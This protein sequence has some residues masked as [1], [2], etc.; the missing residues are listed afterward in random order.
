[1]DLLIAHGTLV[2]MDPERRIIE[3]GAVL[4]QG[5]RIAAVGSAAELREHYPDVKT[6]DAA[7]RVVTPGLVNTHTHLFQGLLKGL[8]DD[9]VLV[10]WFRQ[11]TGPSAVHLTP[12][13][14]YHAARLG[15]LE[16]IRS[17]A[18]TLLDFMYPHAQPGLSAPI[19]RAFQESGIRG[20]FARGYVDYGLEEGVPPEII[21]DT[22]QA[23]A[24][25][26]QLFENYHGSAEGRIQVWV[27]PCMIW[28]QT[29]GGLLA[30]R[31]LANETGMRISVHVAETPFE[32][33]NAR[34]RFGLKDLEYLASIGFLG[35]DVLAV[36]GVYLDERDIR[37]L[38]QHDVKLSHNPVS[39]MYLSSGVAPIPD[40]L[41]AGITVGLATDGPASNN[42]QNMIQTLKFTALLHKVAT[43]D[44]TVI[45]AEK[46]ME[47]ATID[48][49]RALGLEDEIGSIEVGKKADLI[50]LNFGSPFASPVHHPVSSLV[51]SAIG[52]E[53]E[54]VIVDGQVVMEGSQVSTMDE[55]EVVR[56]AQA[57]ADHLAQRAGTTR[58]RRRPWRSLAY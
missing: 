24:D 22:H 12:E 31:R 19:I 52:N 48:G 28:T 30:T 3:D 57:A 46:V 39:N 55:E 20:V 40:M 4:I 51:Y 34:R 5:Q 44:P 45:T 47:M 2:T 23:L 54:A 38:K 8:G 32:L 35:P 27:A 9:R 53:V 33:E 50:V 21:E 6:L 10:D 13:D 15:C 42:N 25:C 17:G 36:H 41:M 16:S 18:T 29:E 58:F 56:K 49:A 7:G 11:V 14:C 43:K 26:R 1:M 37:I